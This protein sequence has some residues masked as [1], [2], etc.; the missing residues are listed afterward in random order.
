MKKKSIYG[1]TDV[2][3]CSFLR[4]SV[5]SPTAINTAKKILESGFVY[6]SGEKV[7]YQT[8][9]SNIPFLLRF[10]IDCKVNGLVCGNH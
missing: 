7:A 1:Y 2:E 4:I 8:F 9:E 10:M 5:T 3:P 6:S